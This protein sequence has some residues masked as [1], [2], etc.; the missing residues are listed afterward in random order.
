MFATMNSKAK[1]KK[2][3]EETRLNVATCRLARLLEAT[4]SNKWET[5]LNCGVQCR[6][7]SWTFDVVPRHRGSFWGELALDCVPVKEGSSARLS[8]ALVP[9]L[10]F[11]PGLCYQKRKRLLQHN[12]PRQQI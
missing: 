11:L 12:N 7:G 4:D 2:K 3:K 10:A 9:C 5:K 6:Q 8:R 1:K